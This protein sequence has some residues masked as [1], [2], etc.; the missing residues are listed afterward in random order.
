MSDSHNERAHARLS[1]S[2]ANRWINCPASPSIEELFPDEESE[3]A[4]EGTLAHEFAEIEQ[5]KYLE[6]IDSLTYNTRLAELRSH[7]LYSAGME[8]YVAEY[9]EYVL[10]FYYDGKA[11]NVTPI[12][13]YVEEKLDLSKYI[14]DGFGTSDNIILIGKDLHVFDLKF[15]YLPVSAI[16]NKQLRIYAV[17][18]Y[19]LL[20]ARGFQIENVFMHI[21]QPRINNYSTDEIL[22]DE[23]VHWAETDLVMF[24]ERADR[25]EGGQHSG[26]HCQFCKLHVG[27]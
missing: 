21:V 20:K 16:D 6:R 14:P 25:G 11:Q 4:A 23:L 22:I 27:I 10:A 3:A 9:V 2:G 12:E 8:D 18:A 13:I 24:A 15:G 19:E 5:N 17:G 7:D 26:E 1:A